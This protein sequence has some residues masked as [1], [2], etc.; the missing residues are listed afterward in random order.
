LVDGMSACQGADPGPLCRLVDHFLRVR[1]SLN[2]WRVL[3]MIQR[4]LTA[5]ACGLLLRLQLLPAELEV[6]PLIE[7]TG[8]AVAHCYIG[9]DM[10]HRFSLVESSPRSR[11]SHGRSYCLQGGLVAG[12]VLVA[13]FD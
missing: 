1:Q 2:S 3:F 6:V 12:L 7:L 11:N 8:C 5:C 4:L 9:E 13:R 10:T